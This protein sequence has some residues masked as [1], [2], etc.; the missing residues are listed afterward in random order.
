MSIWGNVILPQKDGFVYGAK[1]PVVPCLWFNTAGAEVPSDPDVSHGMLL[2]R[3]TE[4]VLH[5]LYPMTTIAAVYGLNDTLKKI[6]EDNNT[7][8]VNLSLPASDWVGDSAPYTQ[9]VTVEGLTDGRQIEVHPAYSDDIDANLAMRQACGF[10]SYAKRNGQ[11]VTFTCLEDKPAVDIGV[12][13]K[14][15]V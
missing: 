15:Y 2:Y 13:A 12:I 14:L 6:S 8:S 3:D 5:P 4:D 1:E 7:A 11:N 10:L 9:T